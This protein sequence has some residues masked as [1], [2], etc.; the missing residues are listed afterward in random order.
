[1]TSS[2]NLRAVMCMALL[3]LCAAAAWKAQSSRNITKGS[4]G[5]TVVDRTGQQWSSTAEQKIGEP[6]MLGSSVAPNPGVR[7]S[8]K[9]RVLPGGVSKK[10]K[11]WRAALTKEAI[12]CGEL[13]LKTPH[14]PEEMVRAFNLIERKVVAQREL[15]KLGNIGRVKQQMGCYMGIVRHLQL[16][17]KT[18]C[19]I[20]VNAGH[21]SALML[22]NSDASNTYIGFDLDP[23]DQAGVNKQEQHDETTLNVKQQ[24]R[25]HKAH[26]HLNEF[27]HGRFQLVL[28]D[29]KVAGPKYLSQNNVTCALLSIDGDHSPRGINGDWLAFRSFVEPGTLVLLDDVWPTHLVWKNKDLQKVGCMKSTG[30]AD[31]MANLGS[32]PSLPAG[33]NFCV[34]K[35]V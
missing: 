17:Q 32:D 34:G 23:A 35:K 9:Q 27:F 4:Q 16:R 28:G 7:M 2:P 25:V 14:F 13:Q 30:V 24:S 21:S 33:R 11:V 20:G 19:E 15:A 10:Q 6:F 29:S 26:M 12:G 18:I 22:A 5:V 8:K 1:M 3:I 31:D